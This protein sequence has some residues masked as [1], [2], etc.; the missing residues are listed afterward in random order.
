[1]EHVNRTAR[2]F[3]IVAA[4]LLGSC[5]DYEGRKLAGGY[6]LKR[7]DD[8]AR[9]ALIVTYGTGSLII[10]EIG[11]QKP[12]IIARPAGSSDWIA[13]NTDRARH[14]WISDKQ[15]KSDEDYRG[16][17]TEP[18]AAAWNKINARNRLW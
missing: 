17:A 6:R 2:I 14:S 4:L 3:F 15:R 16:I 13:I 11:W 8:G 10:D 18:V 7:G 5:G 9:F 12:I 1:V